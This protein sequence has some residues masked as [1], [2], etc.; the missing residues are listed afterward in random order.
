MGKTQKTGYLQNIVSYDAS[1]N[2][3]LPANLTVLG[4]I[5]GYATSSSLSGYVTLSTLQTIT[6]IKTFSN[7]ALFGNGVTINGGYLSIKNGTNIVTLD[8]ATLSANRAILLPNASGTIALTSDIPSLTGYATESY[9]STAVSNL[10]NSAPSTL[11]TL[12]ELATALGN[13]ANFSTTIST[14]LGN[15]LRIDIGTQ[16]LT[17]TQQGYGRTNLGLGTAAT[18]S[19]SDFAA[20][21]HTHSIANVTGL[22]TAL[23]GKEPSI[24][25]GTTAQYWRGDKTW[26]TLP[27]YTL[28]GLGGVP[29]SRTITINGVAYDLTADR[30]WS[31]AAG[32]TSFNTRTGAITLSSSD[33]TTALG[34]TP[35]NAT[36]PNGYITSSSNISGTSAGISSSAPVLAVASESNSIYVTAPSYTTGQ[37]TKP[38]IF[39]WYGNY[40]TIGN[41]RSGGVASNGFGIGFQSITPTHI[42]TTTGLTINGNTAYHSGNLTN[43]NQLSNGPGYITGYTETD[44]L[45]SVTARGASTSTAISLSGNLTMSGAGNSTSIIFGDTSKRI[46]VEGYWMMFKGHENEGFRWQTAGQDGVT[47]TTRMQLTSSA[48]TVNGNTVL[49]AGNYNSY[50]PTLTGGNAS[51]TWGI[52][53]TGSSGSA[54]SATYADRLQ[55]GN[56][57]WNWATGAHTATNPNTITL[58]D[59]YSNYGGNGYP[60]T[61]GTIVDIYG[62]SGHEHDQILMDSGGTMY[63]R[64]CFY[65]TNS[66]N[67]WKTMVDSSN[68]GSYAITSLTDTL[69]SVTGRG[70]ST[71]TFSTFSGGLS[72]SSNPIYFRGSSTEFITGEGWDTGHYPYN[73]NDG[74]LFYH[75][76][77]SN[78]PH[79]AFHIG[80]YNNAGY[81]GYSDGDSIITLVRGD[82]TKSQGSSYAGR[83]LSDSSYYTNIVKTTS[84]TIFRD[85][86]GWHSFTGSIRTNAGV[87][88]AGSQATVVAVQVLG[89]GSYPSIELGTENNYDG[90]IRSYGNDLRYYAGHWRTV[91]VG[92]SEDHSHYWYTSRNGSTDWSTAKMRLDH[93]GT[94]TVSGNVST[95]RVYAG[96]GIQLAGALV[97]QG[98]GATLDN[99]TGARLSESYGAVWNFSNSATWHHQVVNGSYLCGFYASGGNYGSGNYYGTGDVTAYYSDERLKTK[100]TTITNAIEKIQ[101][102]EGF[103]YI[104]N[105]LAKSFGY[106][107]EKE[108]AGVSAQQIQAVLPQAVSLA[109]FDMQ[110]VAN[111]GEVISKSGENYLTVKYDRIVPLLI[112]GIKEQQKQI[113]EL[114]NK[115][116]G[117]TK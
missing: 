33:V 101:S 44:T 96:G 34:Y 11:D 107:N 5:T 59:Q 77:T 50:A 2:V 100:V 84:Q 112:E 13:D 115:L 99:S 62:R 98:S 45:A 14:S 78:N 18:A 88:G 87:A 65:G 16:G 23:D 57:Q 70:A 86:Q 68:I 51:G 41:I 39:D 4:T 35:Y 43:L 74:F 17:S 61:Y 76:D 42:F 46:N 111:T 85:A 24:T 6:G 109:P 26:Q 81:A 49:H 108:Q 110:G 73:Y 19:T 67:G 93:N 28:S 116:N 82:G 40:W 104:E 12:S 95:S 90:V 72:V 94:L 29:T 92:A 89:Y 102:L 10:V 75:R 103:I 27:V 21:S 1:G 63:H 38:I 48:L 37:I 8:S 54:G 22:Q 66:W 31:I 71:A 15:R 117:I 113:E 105:E 3:I 91:G 69:G 32:V 36:N 83:G 97:L 58:W 52:N 79:P 56:N 30:S 25:A 53:V 64:N 47:Y 80:G 106:T 60:V 7:E 20:A 9:V 55:T 114:K